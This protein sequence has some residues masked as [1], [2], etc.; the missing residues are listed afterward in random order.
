MQISDVSLPDLPLG[1]EGF[2]SNEATPRPYP[3]IAVAFSTCI[4]LYKNMKLFYK[5]YLPSADFSPS[6]TEIWKQLIDPQNHNMEVVSLLAENLN[7]LPHKVLSAQSHEFLTLNS[8]HQLEYIEQLTEIPTRKL[9]EIACI[10]TLKMHSIERYSMS[11]LVVGTEDGQVIILDS[12]TFAQLSSAK[13]CTVKRTPFLI[14]PTGLYNVDYRLTVATREKCVCLLKRDWS[15]G[16]LLFTTDEHI[17]SMELVSADNSVMIICS[18]NTL[19]CYSKKG[20]KQWS[21]CLEHRPVATTI[22]RV[23]PLSLTLTAVALASGHVHLFDGQARR[24][25][26]FVRD[27]V[28]VMKFG[29]LGQEEHVFIII[30]AGG[31]LMLKILKRTAE[32]GGQVAAV[33]PSVGAQLSKPWHLPKKSKLFLEQKKLHTA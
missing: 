8:E 25:T 26:I 9:T 28:S 7:S 27:V 32:F 18:D 3:V 22:A 17:I 19:T 21:V 24:D 23:R 31:N 6:E 30:T 13:L 12:Q 4:Y 1:V 10:T 5:Y 29:Q 11:C 14:V 16:R 33:E 15:E 2:Y 20:K